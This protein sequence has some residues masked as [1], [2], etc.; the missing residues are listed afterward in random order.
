MKKL[1]P[2]WCALEG[3][4]KMGLSHLLSGHEQVALNSVCSHCDGN[5]VR[6]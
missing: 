1:G 6:H 4:M 3:D 5:G 2:W